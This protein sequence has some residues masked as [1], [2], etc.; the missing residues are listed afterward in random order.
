MNSSANKMTTVGP[1]L[2]NIVQCTS[3]MLNEY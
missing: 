1:D 3:C 2:T